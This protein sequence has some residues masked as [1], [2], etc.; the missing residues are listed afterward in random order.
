MNIQT[1]HSIISILDKIEEGRFDQ[2]DIKILLID[3]RELTGKD[4]DDL[5]EIA[6]FVAHPERTRGLIFDELRKVY[7]H[8]YNT[9]DD[10]WACPSDYDVIKT[11]IKGEKLIS[12]LVDVIKKFNLFR[13]SAQIKK[14]IERSHEISI[15]I[16]GLLTDARVMVNGSPSNLCLSVTPP[17]RISLLA[18]IKVSKND[19]ALGIMWPIISTVC[20]VSEEMLS[21]FPPFGQTEHFIVR[22]SEHG[23]MIIMKLPKP[24]D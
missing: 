21:I 1:K 2:D 12:Q 17:N 5:K 16:I 23:H 9:F 20:P 4:E 18:N 7:E 3:I 11:V 22:R 24:I 13:D 15:C 6:H 10:S 8:I 14:M 19:R